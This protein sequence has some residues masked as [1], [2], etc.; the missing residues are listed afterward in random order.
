M[1]QQW[2]TRD[3]E[4]LS[5]WDIYTA[6]NRGKCLHGEKQGK[7]SIRQGIKVINERNPIKP[8]F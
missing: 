5:K 2:Y 4:T 6:Q 7:K 1:N 3:K 8:N